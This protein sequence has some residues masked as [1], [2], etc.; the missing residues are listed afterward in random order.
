MNRLLGSLVPV[1]TLLAGCAMQRAG[2]AER[3]RTE[4]V[5]MSKKDLLM[6]A[7]VPARQERVDD[8]EF[9]TYTGGGDSVGAAYA[10]STSPA[11]AVAV[12]KRTQRY[13][14]ATFTL[15][16]GVVQQVRYSGRTGGLLSRGEQCAFIVENCALA[17]ERL[18][19]P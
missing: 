5:G 3:A 15:K 6:C 4:M 7:G 10:R 14:E 19:S 16:D 13:C 9:L 18:P 2:V 1:V 11:T 17:K 8:L 12:G